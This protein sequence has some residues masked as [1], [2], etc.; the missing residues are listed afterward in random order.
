MSRILA[1]ILAVSAISM[2]LALPC[3]FP[4]MAAEENYTLDPMHTNIVW[5]AN[6]F[7]FS[8]PSGKFASVQGTLTL[9]EAKPENSKVSVTISTTSVLTGIEKL[10]AHLRSDA[11]FNVEKFPS[12]TFVSDKVETTGKNTAKVYGNLTLHGITKPVVLDVTLN[13]IGEHPMT[14]KKT[15]GF[16]ATT[17]LKRSD[18]GINYALPGVA[19]DVKIAIES[20]ANLS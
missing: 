14:K 6:H 2:S 4:A 10:D 11:F 7:G 16:S 18:F 13:K 12:A 3:A 9:D 15:A 1:K 19:D 5:F 20:E 8:N 17:V